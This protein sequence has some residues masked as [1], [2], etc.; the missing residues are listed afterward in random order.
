MAD[1]I[2][3]CGSVNGWFTFSGGDTT[4]N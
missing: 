2:M 3:H 4:Y 1:G